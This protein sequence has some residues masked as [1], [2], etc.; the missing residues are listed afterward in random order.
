[1]RSEHNYNDGGS[2]AYPRQFG[3][4]FLSLLA[5]EFFLQPSIGLNLDMDA[6]EKD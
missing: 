6:N 4:F 3:F 2:K 5:V 1:M